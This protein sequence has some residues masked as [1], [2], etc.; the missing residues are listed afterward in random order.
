[1]AIFAG[2]GS[3]A[4]IAGKFSVFP[5]AG[6]LDLATSELAAIAK[7]GLLP[8]LRAVE[9]GQ[10]SDRNVEVVVTFVEDQQRPRFP[11]PDR[12]KKR[13]ALENRKHFRRQ[14]RGSLRYRTCESRIRIASPVTSALSARRKWSASG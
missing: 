7:R 8:D 11:K 14:A 13:D 6:L 2:Q 4:G 1:L 10:A 9:E 12:T 3:S 5:I